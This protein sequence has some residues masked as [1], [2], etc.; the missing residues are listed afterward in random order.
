MVEAHLAGRHLDYYISVVS[1]SL[2][3]LIS[4]HGHEVVSEGL[5]ADTWGAKAVELDWV[6]EFKRTLDVEHGKGSKS[7]T[8]G[9]ASDKYLGLGVKR[10]QVRKMGSKLAGDSTVGSVET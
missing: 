1:E 4:K 5:V 3:G 9:V 7:T 8:K 10:N 2:I 6:C